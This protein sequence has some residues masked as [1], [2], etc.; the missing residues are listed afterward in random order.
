M[1]RG[2]REVSEGGEETE[3]KSDSLFFVLKTSNILL[4][5]ASLDLRR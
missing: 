1:M 2:E 5:L 4:V 3:L